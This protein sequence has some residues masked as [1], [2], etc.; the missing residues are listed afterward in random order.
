MT[1]FTLLSSQGISASTVATS[2]LT[3]IA[4]IGVFLIACKMM[5]NNLESLSSNKLKALFAK[6]SKSKLI[7]VGIGTVATAAIQSS[8]ATTVM[9]IGF[10]NAGIMS[11]VQ[12]ATIIFGANI[13][14]TITG[15]IVALGLFG[16]NT[17]SATVIFSAFA[18]IGACIMLFAKK[19]VLQKIGGILAGFGM[20]FVGL[21][22][23][24]G[25]MEEFAMLDAV[26][27]FLASISNPIL[28][29]LIGVVLTAIIQS[30][31]VMTSLAITMV[32]TG[33]INLDQGIYLTLGSNIGS[34]AVALIAGIGSNTNA[35][36]TAIIHLIFNVSGVVV[37]MIVG[38]I[39]RLASKGTI[40]FGLLFEKMFP[41][42]L[43]TQMAMFHTI[44]NVIT[45]IL[46]LPLTNLLVK[47]VTKIIPE[48]KTEADS[49][50]PRTY[51]IDEHLLSTP[52]IAVQQTKNEIVNMAEI[53]MRNFALSCEIVCTMDFSELD[54]FRN[55]EI[56]L[57]FLNKEIVHFVIKL[58]KLEMSDSDRA[59]LSSALHT[60]TDLERIGD[61]AENII[62]YAE[63]LNSA[64]EAFSDDA[65]AEIRDMEELIE[66]LYNK[67]MKAYVNRDFAALKEANEIEERIDDITDAMAENHIRRIDEGV[68]TSEIGAQYMSLASNA[69]RVADHFINVAKTI[70]DYKYS[71]MPTSRT[72]TQ[73][74][75]VKNT[76]VKT[77]NKN[78]K[79]KAKK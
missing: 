20:L 6:T 25:A 79:D 65:I 48:K 62:E 71:K 16:A 42:A 66:D 51:Y 47:F 10:V 40:S 28:L 39:M 7:G 29:V 23:M 77:T 21:N 18:G 76:N 45:V 55:N 58:S 36:R 73:S 1:F 54:N 30:S 11:L 33:L 74:K 56:E 24:S 9:V 78:N 41:N 63:K 59:Y 60:I 64:N 17:I 26:K 31:S 52:P 75:R 57:D 27:A 70:R 43:N 53:A 50:A 61:Y 5:S 35:K 13:G 67:V 38:M 69:E 49:N 68:C 2:I 22:M 12:A 8:G 15:Q 14:T 44:F 3:L 37:F 72:N 19:D 34:C 46:I 4:G 32:F